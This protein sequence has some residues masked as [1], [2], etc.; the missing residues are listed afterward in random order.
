MQTDGLKDGRTDIHDGSN[1]KNK[2]A[3]VVLRYI[4]FIFI[5]GVVAVSSVTH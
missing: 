4:K 2:S 1:K 3:S 5:L